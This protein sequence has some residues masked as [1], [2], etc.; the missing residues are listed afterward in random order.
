MVSKPAAT[1]HP[2]L[3][4]ELL[5]DAAEC[6]RTLAHPHR[7]RMVQMLLRVVAVAVQRHT[8]SISQSIGA[9]Y[10]VPIKYVTAL[11]DGTPVMLSAP[12]EVP[13]YAR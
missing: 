1:D 10:A 13:W 12:I 3:D 7:L 9:T 2:L 6:L 5:A 11:I 8:G 4:L